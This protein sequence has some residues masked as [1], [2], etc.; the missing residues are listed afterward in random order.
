MSARRQGT[1]LTHAFNAATAKR[2][3]PESNRCKRLCRPLRNHSAKAP[4]AARVA[5][6]RLQLVVELKRAAGLTYR[7]A[8]LL[9]EMCARS[10]K[11]LSAEVMEVNPVLDV[12]NRTGHLAMELILSL[13]GKRIL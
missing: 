9:A 7:E 12:A 4:R 1:R 11:V 8:H 3:L 2:R 13:L 6:D 10:G 5:A